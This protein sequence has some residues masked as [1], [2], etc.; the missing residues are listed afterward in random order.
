MCSKQKKYA[1]SS[2]NEQDIK[3]HTKKCKVLLV[4]IGCSQPW[5]LTFQ[6]WDK[7]KVHC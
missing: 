5:G 7:T 1:L 2:M 3:M 4:Y 6:C